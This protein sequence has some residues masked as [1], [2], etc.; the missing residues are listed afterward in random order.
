MKAYKS[1]PL[2]LDW[3]E[4]IESKVILKSDS[5]LKLKI[6]K[7]SI[8]IHRDRSY[9]VND[10]FAY[11]YHLKKDTSRYSSKGIQLIITPSK[12]ELKKFN[13]S[14][15][16]LFTQ[17]TFRITKFNDSQLN[18]E[19]FATDNYPINPFFN[20]SIKEY[21]FQKTSIDTIINQ[22]TQNTGWFAQFDNNN[23]LETD[24]II[25]QK[26]SIEANGLK[27]YHFIFSENYFEENVLKS[28]DITPQFGNS[29]FYS[30]SNK[31]W[32]IVNN[33]IVIVSYGKK[34]TYDYKFI[35]KKLFLIKNG[36]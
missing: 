16:K 25:L 19:T 36:S 22:L 5:L 24:T 23:I 30:F 35:D 33:Q 6:T 32:F 13:K 28:E 31:T 34:T 8:Y 12:K 7:D 11:S 15:R 20:M 9:G 10:S 26:D 2:L 18:I 17:I 3:D 21:S 14:L 4:E 1:S 27:H 29:V